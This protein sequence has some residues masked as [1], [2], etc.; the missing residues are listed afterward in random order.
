[1]V[2][3]VTRIRIM[4]DAAPTLLDLTVE[5]KSIVARTNACRG[6]ALRVDVIVF[7][8]VWGVKK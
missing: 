7:I 5:A 8:Q 4:S 2:A 6:V 1:M 3:S